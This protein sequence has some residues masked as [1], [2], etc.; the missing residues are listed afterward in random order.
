MKKGSRA[1]APRSISDGVL[2]IGR[3]TI[4]ELEAASTDEAAGG[5]HSERPAFFV[6]D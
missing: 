2:T 1:T 5:H 4:R 3:T 6:D